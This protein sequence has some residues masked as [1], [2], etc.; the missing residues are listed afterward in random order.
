MGL[1][2]GGICFIITLTVLRRS[3]F[4]S[5]KKNAKCGNHFG[6]SN[7]KDQKFVVFYFDVLRDSSFKKLEYRENR[8]SNGHT[9]LGDLN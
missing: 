8:L 6:P 5:E 2:V 4:W 1:R 9:A 3:L 7:I